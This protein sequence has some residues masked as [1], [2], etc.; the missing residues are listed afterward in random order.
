M[1]NKK[2]CTVYIVLAFVCLGAIFAL[3]VSNAGIMAEEITS[4]FSGKTT[5]AEFTTNVQDGYVSDTF[6]QKNFFINLN[7]LFARA[8]NRRVYNNSV[9]MDNGSL[10]RTTYPLI[11]TK[12]NA[13]ALATF[14]DIAHEQYGTDFVYV[15]APGKPGMD[16]DLLPLGLEHNDKENADHMVADLKENGIAVLD[17]RQELSGTAEAINKYFYRTDHHWNYQG[18]FLGTQRILEFL[19]AQFPQWKI[20]ADNISPEQWEEHTIENWFLGSTGKRVGAWYA[21]ADDFTYYTPYFETE[22][23]MAVPKHQYVRSGTFEDTIIRSETYL[24][25]ETDYFTHNHYCLYVGGDY[26]VVHHRNASAPNKQR[27]LLVR[28]S[29]S[30]PVQAYL[31][32]VFQELEVLDLR[33]YTDYSLLEYVRNTQPDLVLFILTTTSVTN[34]NYIKRLGL[35]DNPSY[36]L[37]NETVYTDFA[38]TPKDNTHRYASVQHQFEAGKTYRVFMKGV[39]VTQ[40]STNGLGLRL[41]NMTQKAT[42]MSDCFH[43]EYQE[44][45]GGYE[46]VFTL[47]ENTEDD[48][49]LLVYAGL[50]GKTNQ[51]GVTIDELKIA[52]L[53]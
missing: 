25:K 30:V 34:E 31:S 23:S 40:G 44:N 4:L 39:T 38:I 41:Y 24:D 10:A 27:V 28:D 6:K 32:T 17:L 36:T 46:W 33:Y 22:M 51:I 45:K 35:T 7:G 49:R 21:G 14:A 13:D 2:P 19:Q 5:F 12:G 1:Q 3:A 48:I 52:E 37:A 47:P 15:Q 50:P 8:T 43:I 16:E 42:L 9:L 29:Y 18:A 53:Q 20:N 26:P 11:D